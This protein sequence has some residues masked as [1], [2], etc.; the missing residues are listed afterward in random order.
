ME[1]K[2]LT[3]TI[4]DYGYDGEGVGKVD[5]KVCFIPY[6]IK[7]EKINF[8]VVE[9]KKDYILG[10]LD[11]IIKPSKKR[12]NARC[13]YFGR[14]GGCSYQHISYVEE[15]EIKK[16]L[17]KRQLKKLNYIG[18]IK[19]HKSQNEYNYRNKIK[20]FVGKGLIGLNQ[21]NSNKI[22]KINQ[23]DLAQPLIN[24]AI[25]L[26]NIFVEEYNLYE[27][28]K[29]ITI[30]QEENACLL[31][32][33]VLSLIDDNLLHQLCKKLGE[34][35]G[36]YQSLKDKK[37][38]VC[39]IKYL[40]ISEF[41]LECQYSPY[42]FHQVNDRVCYELYKRVLD[43]VN[44]KNVV[45]CYSGTGVLSGILS[46]KCQK[47]VG[48]ELGLSEHLEAE[49]LKQRNNLKNLKNLHGDCAKLLPKIISEFDTIIIDPP[50]K[51]VDKKVISAID[52]TKFKKL[53]Y[54]SC[55]I[56]TLVRDLKNLNNI[57]L[58]SVELFDMFSRTGEYEMLIVASKC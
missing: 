54:I 40:Q 10:K 5:N 24:K 16:E 3:T 56:A 25:D 23:C 36:I 7:D 53:I 50:R 6:T 57:K 30:R 17:A 55:N 44:G 9:E 11:S 31:N 51:G 37:F 46:K 33:D 13:P 12:I 41:D 48:I 28:I 49:K 22:C 19:V 4:I 39:G 43:E 20:L 27:K 2:I 21:R 18:E 47:V 8:A 35:F 34:G 52:N 15:L 32:F 26:I 14:C 42:S 38:Y 45:N 1:N 58:E 29:T